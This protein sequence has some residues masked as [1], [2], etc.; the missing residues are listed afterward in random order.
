M[1]ALRNRL[2]VTLSDRPGQETF[3]D[4]DRSR[5]GRRDPL[6]DHDARPAGGHRDAVEA[7]GGLH[8]P[9]LMAHDQ[10]LRLATELLDEV[11]RS[12]ERRV[13]KEWRRRWSPPC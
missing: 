10:Q 8:R 13:G 3:L 2:Q 9:L 11:D 12:E 7:V 1:M 5:F 6:R 4:G